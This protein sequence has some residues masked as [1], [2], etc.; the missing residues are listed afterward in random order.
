MTRL[1]CTVVLSSQDKLTCEVGTTHHYDRVDADDVIG[2]AAVGHVRLE[3]PV[4]QIIKFN[5]AIVVPRYVYLQKN[6]HVNA[7]YVSFQICRL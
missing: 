6:A 5:G 1:H 4:P 3:V 2:Q 7:V